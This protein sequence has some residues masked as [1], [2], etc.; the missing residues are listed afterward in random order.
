MTACPKQHHVKDKAYLA[1]LRTQPCVVT[2][3]YGSDYETIDPAHFRYG[4]D[5]GMGKKPSDSLAIPMIHSEHVEQHKKG[6]RRY[7]LDAFERD[8]GLMAE[9]IR[10]ALKWR[11]SI[12][13][14]MAR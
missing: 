14:G 2:G 8:P 10:D 7:W 4:A 6:E 5:G 9:F 3:H 11:Y 12:W 1:W 13:K